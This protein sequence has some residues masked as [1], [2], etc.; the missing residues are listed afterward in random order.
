MKR[1]IK[2]AEGKL[3]VFIPGMGAITS[4]VLAGIFNIR[5]GLSKPIGS[6]TQMG[7]IRLGK[8]TDNRSPL[9]K[10]FVPLHQLTILNLQDGMFLKMICMKRRKKLMSFS[11]NI[12]NR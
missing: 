10:D 9:I 2:P 8:R 4:T 7:R 6:V 1:S 11:R 12:L 3:M 5:K